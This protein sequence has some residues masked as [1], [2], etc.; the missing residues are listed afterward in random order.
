MKII[1]VCPRYYPDIGGVETDVKEIS[2]RLVKRGFEVEVICTDPSGKHPKKEFI[3]G[4]EV[5]RFR[6]I[7]PNDAYFFAPQIYF[8]LKKAN[9]DLIHA[10]NYHAL[11]AFFA[12]L[13]KNG[14]KFVFTSYYHGK[15]HTVLRNIL[16]KP[17]KFLGSRIFKNADR[18]ICIS[19]Y[20]KE[21][22]K[23]NF[24]LPGEKLVH[25]PNGIN[26]EEFRIKSNVKDKKMILYVGRLERYKG[27]Q[28]IIRALQYL[29]GYRLM[30]VG[31]GPYEGELRKLASSTNVNGRIGWLKDLSREE[32]LEQYKS[33]GVF[34]FL[35]SFEAF[36]IT[37]AEALASGTPC[38]VAETGAL[39]EFIDEKICF[40]LRNPENVNELAEKIIEVSKREIDFFELPKDKIK[41]RSWDEVVDEHEKIYKEIIK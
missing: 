23:E 20:E 26:L 39:K 32:L 6:S 21:L 24:G 16:H 31:K 40:G 9:C 10:H 1:Q 41:I 4:V 15:G 22:I 5:R 37:V 14:R 30:I 19:I 11:P 28:H 17:Y 13:V 2:E 8:Y 12:A 36:G 7:A 18:V 27:V 33:A 3:N 34:I 38:I 35:S 25:I 29:D